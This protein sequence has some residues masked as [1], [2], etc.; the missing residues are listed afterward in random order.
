MRLR[1]YSDARPEA[2]GADRRP[3]DPVARDEVLRAL[4]AQ[5][6]H[7]LPRL[8]GRRRSR[9]TSSTT[10]R[11]SRTTSSCRTAAARSSCSS[12]DIDD[13]RITF[14]DTGLD[15]EHR[16]A[17]AGRARAPRRTTRCSW[18]T[19]ATASPTRRSTRS[20]TTSRARTQGRQLPV[21][22]AARYTFH[23]VDDAATAT[24]SA[25]IAAVADARRL[26]QRRLLRPPAGDLRLHRAR[27]R[28][29]SRSR[30]SG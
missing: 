30:S 18:P 16:R 10:T 11:R 2:D 26:D 29:W 9:S 21:R 23:V 1:E 19:T 3:P 12:S 25:A 20:S 24:G 28:S 7:P 5:G 4:R 13:W 15:A 27:A 14:V 22:P 8:Q 6:L 17:A